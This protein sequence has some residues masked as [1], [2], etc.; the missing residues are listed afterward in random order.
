MTAARDVFE[1]RC[2]EVENL[3]AYLEE[4]ENQGAASGGD[5]PKGETLRI[6]RASC[7]VMIYN[8]VES[9]VSV[10][11]QDL[12]SAVRGTASSI[13]DLKQEI[14]DLFLVSKYGNRILPSSHEKAAVFA[15][16][17]LNDANASAIPEFVFSAPSGNCTDS[18]VEKT[19]RKVGIEFDVIPELKVRVKRKAVNDRTL[20]E[21]LVMARN[22]LAHGNRAF[23]EVGRD[24]T[25]AD[26][27]EIFT[28]AS[29]Y[30]GVVVTHFE[31][32]IRES[33][34]LGSIMRS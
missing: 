32:Y 18:N 22:D 15:R 27:R 8:M 21:A 25:A 11:L 24:C 14:F 4:V 30:M 17:L 1:E 16:D 34:Y 2:E 31:D 23:S 9:T 6:L 7:Y 3:V 19:I 33:G 5:A 20:L 13:K 28:L 10:C 29:E 26:L 12:S